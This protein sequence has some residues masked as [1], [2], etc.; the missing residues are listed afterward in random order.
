MTVWLRTAIRAGWVSQ[1]W[2]GGFPRYVWYRDSGTW[3]EGR[4][5]NRLLGHYKGYPLHPREYPRGLAG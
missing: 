5:V 4:L 2:E 1:H 3:Y